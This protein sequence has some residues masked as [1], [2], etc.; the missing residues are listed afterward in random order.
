MFPSE[1]MKIFTDLLGRMKTIIDYYVPFGKRSGADCK[2][3]RRRNVNAASDTLSIS[4]HLILSGN[5]QLKKW[6]L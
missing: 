4:H 3:D 6:R 1:I 5:D 2:M